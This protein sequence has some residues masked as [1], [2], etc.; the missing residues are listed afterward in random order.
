MA[1]TGKKEAAG[2]TFTKQQLL[3]A[4]KFANRRDLLEALLEEGKPYSINE[5]EKQ[6]HGYLGRKVK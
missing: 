4:E 5:V 2:C 1:N 3:S 6:M